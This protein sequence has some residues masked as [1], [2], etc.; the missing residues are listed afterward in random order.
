MYNNENPKT[1]FKLSILSFK[2]LIILNY[3]QNSVNAIKSLQ[4]LPYDLL[5]SK[6]IVTYAGY[7]VADF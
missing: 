1:R 3:Q 7:V 2:T 6:Y 4:G 5:K